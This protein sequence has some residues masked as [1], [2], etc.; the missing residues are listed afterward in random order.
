M[1]PVSFALVLAVVFF[2]M[3]MRRV[4]RD[5]TMPAGFIVRCTLA[6]VPTCLLS[7]LSSRWSSPSAVALMIPAGIVLLVLGFRALKVIGTEEKELIMRL[8][9]PAKE[10]LLSM[11]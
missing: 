6:G 4:R 1:V 9:I 7:I 5:V 3:V 2:H 10:R 11:F 8:P